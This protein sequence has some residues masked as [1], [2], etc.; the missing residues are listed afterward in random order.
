MVYNELPL[1][2]LDFWTGLWIVFFCL[3]IIVFFGLLFL[4][5]ARGLI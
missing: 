4:L 1:E 3:L 2:D 5:V